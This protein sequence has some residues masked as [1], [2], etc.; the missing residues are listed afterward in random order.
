MNLKEVKQEHVKKLKDNIYEI[1]MPVVNHET[2]TLNID[3]IDNDLRAAEES[4]ERRKSELA[5]A[6]EYLTTLKSIKAKLLKA[7]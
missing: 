2:I 5:S 6:E 1:K 7:K 4:V 3:V